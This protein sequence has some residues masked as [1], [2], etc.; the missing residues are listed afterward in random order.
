MLN[1]LYKNCRVGSESLTPK[2]LKRLRLFSLC[3]VLGFPLF[4]LLATFDVLDGLP[5]LISGLIT[6]VLL[7]S[8]AP[9]AASGFYNQISKCNSR[10][11]E[12]ELAQKQKAEAFTYRFIVAITIGLIVLALIAIATTGLDFDK[13]QF[14]TANVVSIFMTLAIIYLFLPITYIAWTQKPLVLEE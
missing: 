6:G 9:L 11:D 13:V 2:A 12:W 8:S 1:V 14:T 4:M 10:L 3:A 7:A 5:R